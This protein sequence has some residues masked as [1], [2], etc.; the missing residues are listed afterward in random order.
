MFAELLRRAP[1][2]KGLTQEE[3]AARLAAR[4]EK[5]SQTT[6][7]AWHRGVAIPRSTRRLEVIAK[8]YGIP[9]DVVMRAAFAPRPKPQ[10]RFIQAAG[11]VHRTKQAWGA[12]DQ[13]EW[14]EDIARLERQLEEVLSLLRGGDSAPGE[15][16]TS[17]S[18][19]DEAD[20]GVGLSPPA[21]RRSR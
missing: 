17:A 11:R 16:P 7:S 20:V 14:R 6:V 21:G 10:A 2:C 15:A 3:I 19:A 12:E 8:V 4:G 9:L 5:V 13:A 18:P 1:G